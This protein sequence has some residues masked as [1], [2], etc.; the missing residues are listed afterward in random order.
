MKCT[1][2]LA[3]CLFSMMGLAACGGGGDEAS[4]TE[5]DGGA[6]ADGG[7]KAGGDGAEAVPP[8]AVAAPRQV[9]EV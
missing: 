3:G 7:T 2:L 8:T 5:M 9:P 4:T 6:I 1:G